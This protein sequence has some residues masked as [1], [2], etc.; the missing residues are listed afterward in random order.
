[1]GA[2]WIVGIGR[3]SEYVK[4][5]VCKRCGKCC[6]CLALVL[7]KGVSR[8]SWLVKLVSVWH[9]LAMN[10]YFIGEEEGWL[11]YRCG[12][13]REPR[14][15][16]NGHCSIYPLRHRIC[17]FFPRRTLYGHPSLHSD[18]GYKF[19]RRDILLR[20]KDAKEKGDPLFDEVLDDKLRGDN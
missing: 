20:R 11:V 2:D 18:C 14:N 8:H 9:R 6:M 17:R 1:M 5:G 13:Y 16:K 4:T 7:P 15:G 10:F 12:Y 3:N 19:I